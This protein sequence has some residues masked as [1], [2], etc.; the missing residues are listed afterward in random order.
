MI[1]LSAQ[2]ASQGA[3]L[4]SEP[5]EVP[6]ATSGSGRVAGLRSPAPR[7]APLRPRARSSRPA[8]SPAGSRRALPR[9]PAAGGGGGA[10]PASRAWRVHPGVR[11]RGSRPPPP[12]TAGGGAAGPT[13]PR[14]GAQRAALGAGLGAVPT[15]T[16]VHCGDT[17]EDG[18]ELCCRDSASARAGSSSRRRPA[19]VRARSLA[20]AAP[21]APS[22]H[23]RPSPSP[24][25]S[26][27]AP[28]RRRPP[29]HPGA[30]W[31]PRARRERASS[32]PPRRASRRPPPCLP[33]GRPGPFQHPRPALTC[34][35]AQ[36][37]TLAVGSPRSL[38]GGRGRDGRG[39]RGHGGWQCVL[40]F[41]FFL[42]FGEGAGW[43]ES[44][45]SLMVAALL[46]H[47]HRMSSRP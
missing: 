23:A 39:A 18:H 2:A 31:C 14:G 24:R 3:G 10:R 1:K 46:L 44:C 19:A 25:P 7:R 15:L 35:L 27:L 17:S 13:A 5:M 16:A 30:G 11:A 29:A 41:F 43:G 33:R 34:S 37:Q 20:C 4:E 26:P 12:Q 38:H 47:E 9:P 21:G 22:P 28:R 36:P 6:A 42:E 32:G 45:T 8:H 40:D